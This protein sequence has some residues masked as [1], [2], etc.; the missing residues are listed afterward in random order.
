MMSK[1]CHQD[2][3]QRINESTELSR[4]SREQS[5]ENGPQLSLK[6]KGG[7]VSLEEILS[8]SVFCFLRLTLVLL[9][10]SYV[11]F[12]RSLADMHFQLKLDS[13]RS[14]AEDLAIK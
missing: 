3:P 11:S 9:T 1:I 14:C 4:S 10:N 2:G 6:G 5:R 7:G 12:F 8:I 13:L